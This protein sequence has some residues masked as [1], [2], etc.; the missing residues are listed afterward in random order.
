MNSY[1]FS[2]CIL[3]SLKYCY[4]TS[5]SLP[6]KRTPHFISSLTQ[7]P[8]RIWYCHLDQVHTLGYGNQGLECSSSQHWWR[9]SQHYLTTECGL[10]STKRRKEEDMDICNKEEV[11]EWNFQGSVQFQPRGQTMWIMKEAVLPGFEGLERYYTKINRGNIFKWK[12]NNN[13]MCVMCPNKT[14]FLWKLRYL[15]FPWCSKR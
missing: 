1:P 2:A 4:R 10:T 9:A 8:K 15:S 14:G 12:N 7:E 11:G 6:S 3:P 5:Q 13:L